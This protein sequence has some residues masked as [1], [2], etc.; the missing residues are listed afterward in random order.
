MTYVTRFF[1]AT[2]ALAAALS[3]SQANG[4][5]ASWMPFDFFSVGPCAIYRGSALELSMSY[6]NEKVQD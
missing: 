2:T 6:T 1:Y 5:L 4:M 3:R